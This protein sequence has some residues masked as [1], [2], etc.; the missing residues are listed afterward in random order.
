MKKV[1]YESKPLLTIFT[2][3]HSTHTR[4]RVSPIRLSTQRLFLQYSG[5]GIHLLA[6]EECIMPT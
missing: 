3:G 2:I 6:P 1:A 4:L 5:A